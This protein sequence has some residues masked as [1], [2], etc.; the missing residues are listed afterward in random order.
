LCENNPLST[1]I[2][3]LSTTTGF[4]AYIVPLEAR[5]AMLHVLQNS[6]RPH[7]AHQSNLAEDRILYPVLNKLLADYKRVF[8]TSAAIVNPSMTQAGTEM[9]NLTDWQTTRSRVTAYIQSGKLNINTSGSVNVPI[10]IPNGSG[11]VPTTVV[12]YGGYKTGW[13][14]TTILGAG[15]SLPTTVGYAR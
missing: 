1:C 9:K 7:Y 2:L 13:R 10:T 3:P 15:I 6:P 14:S 8:A 5:I 4:D 11:T 12:N